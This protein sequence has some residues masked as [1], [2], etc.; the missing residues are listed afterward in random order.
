MALIRKLPNSRIP[1]SSSV[2]QSGFTLLEVLVA[3]TITAIIGVGIWQILSATIDAKKG[4]DRVS[5]VFE[6]VQRGVLLMERD[7]FQSVTRPVRDLY[8]EYQ[9]AMSTRGNQGDLEL[10]RTGWRNPLQ[11]T[12]SKLQRVAWSLEGNVLHRYYWQ[13]LDRAQDSNPL[14]QKVMEGVTAI[15]LRFLDEDDNWKTEWPSDEMLTNSQAKPEE[16]PL[17][18]AVEVVIVHERFGRI[19]RLFDLGSFQPGSVSS[20]SPQTGSGTGNAGGNTGGGG[21]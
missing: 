2:S 5:N 21:S 6:D 14:D 11:E 3:I 10:T 1:P 13:V 4:V 8:G 19:R 17:P 9:Y 20:G 16:Q 12:R 7:I 18:R 15:E